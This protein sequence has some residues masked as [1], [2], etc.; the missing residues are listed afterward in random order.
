MGQAPDEDVTPASSSAS[1]PLDKDTRVEVETLK[2]EIEQTRSGIG[3]TLQALE[4][5]LTPRNLASDA[6][7][8]VKD[9]A[10]RTMEQAM[11]TASRRMGDM[12]DKTR[13]A[14]Q[15]VA[16]TVR[17]NPWPAVIVGAGLGYVLYRTFGERRQD[18][19]AS[20]NNRAYAYGELY[21]EPYA[22]AEER[23][24]F[25]RRSADKIGRRASSLG[26]QAS[27]T[28]QRTGRMFRDNPLGFGI[29][30]MAVGAAI[31]LSAPETE[32]ENE[33]M[34]ETRDRVVDRARE[35][36]GLNET[37]GASERS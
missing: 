1:E 15:S 4:D 8:A 17:G 33:W 21:D 13:D 9:K 25:V 26:R 24:T 10:A 28:A 12:A 23:E 18:W 30:A 34:G 19:E 5:R 22:S 11:T 35:A 32:T 6:A 16:E 31:G 14:A 20:W 7:A 27:S 2:V 3:E 37:S 29:A 36:A